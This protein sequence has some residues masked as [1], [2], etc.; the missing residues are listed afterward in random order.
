MSPSI[1]HCLLQCAAETGD[2]T[3]PQC[4]EDKDVRFLKNA[5]KVQNVLPQKLNNTQ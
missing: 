4:K 2:L 1:T 3:M 5:G